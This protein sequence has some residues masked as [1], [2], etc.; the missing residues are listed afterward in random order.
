MQHERRTKRILNALRLH[1]TSLWTSVIRDRRRLFIFVGIVVFSLIA[2]FLLCIITITSEKHSRAEAYKKVS[3]SAGFEATIEYDCGRQPCSYDFN[4]YVLNE[5]GQQV[6]V[7]RP[8]KEGK[9]G[10]ALSEGNYILLI[11]KQFGQDT[12]FPQE[13]L[14]LKNAQL[15]ELKL[16]YKE[17]K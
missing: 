3:G 13:L 8:S 17:A 1:S 4:V 9:V 5:Q 11:G 14:K 10:A 16:R 15:L 6:S 2:I 12:L 7:L